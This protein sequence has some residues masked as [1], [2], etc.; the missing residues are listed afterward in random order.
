[1]NKNNKWFPF[2]PSTEV[3]NPSKKQ[4]FCFPFAGGSAKV[5]RPWLK[6]PSKSDYIPVELPGRG[7]RMT[8]TPIDNMHELIDLFIPDL[9]KKATHPFTFFGHSLGAAL[10]FDLAWTL[11]Q[12]QLPMPDMIIVAGRNA[13]HMPDSSRINSGMNDQELIKELKRLN[14]T[15]KE[16]LENQEMLSFMMPMIRGDLSLHESFSYHEQKLS[17]P[18]IAHCGKLD[19]EADKQIMSNW[20]AMTNSSFEI[21]EFDGDHFFVQHLGQYYFESLDQSISN[22]INEKNNQLNSSL[23]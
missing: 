1:M 5:F 23:T 18:I 13:P 17:I 6:Y 11:Q 21:K 4:V 7:I 16:I 3:E 12:R 9:L 15:P 10:C 2:S 20:A 22:G 19:D 14:G 8:E